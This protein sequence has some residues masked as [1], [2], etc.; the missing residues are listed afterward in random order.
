MEKLYYSI[1]EI[2]EQLNE[3]SHTIRYW[4]QQFPFLKSKKTKTGARLYTK[5]QLN[6]FQHIHKEIN[7][8]NMSVA[9]LK[10]KYKKQHG[11]TTDK[12]QNSDSNTFPKTIDL[13]GKIVLSKEEFNEIILLFKMMFELIKLEEQ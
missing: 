8:N 2:S 9:G 3:P 7:I 4:E 5:E 13:K 11:N 12:L 1:N 6:K 10:K